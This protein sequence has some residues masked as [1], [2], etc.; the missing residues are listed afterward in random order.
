MPTPAT[1]TRPR[2]PQSHF[3]PETAT[4][5]YAR[6]LRRDPLGQLLAIATRHA[7]HGLPFSSRAAM[8]EGCYLVEQG[9]SL[10]QARRSFLQA[11]L[12]RTGPNHPDY[13][14]AAALVR[15]LDAA[16]SAS[17]GLAA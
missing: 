13:H 3:E 7:G 12:H 16:D 5:L 14:R 2:Q 17:L 11:I 1:L 4:Q 9:E 6:N 10:Y 15:E 8:S